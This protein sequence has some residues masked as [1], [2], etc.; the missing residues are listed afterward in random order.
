MLTFMI[1][2]YKEQVF[3]EFNIKLVKELDY[4]DSIILA[5]GHRVQKIIF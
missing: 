4:Y 2:K 3:N 1:Q 5:V